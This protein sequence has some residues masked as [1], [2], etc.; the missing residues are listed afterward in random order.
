[1]QT[2]KTGDRITVK[3]GDVTLTGTAEY[4]SGYAVDFK[5]DGAEQT[6]S[7][8]TSQWAIEV[9]T[10]KNSERIEALK[11]GSVFHWNAERMH[12]VKLADGTLSVSEGYVSRPN[13]Y[14]WTGF[15]EEHWTLHIDYEA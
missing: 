1:M 6:V 8:N 3:M 10:P 13:Q 9:V 7:L 2:I 12:Y 5:A 4:A 14:G 15:D 11:P